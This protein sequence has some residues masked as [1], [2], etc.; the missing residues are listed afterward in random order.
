MM[1]SLKDFIIFFC[2]YDKNSLILLI[3][4]KPNTNKV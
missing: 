4:S 1:K 3:Q 2:I